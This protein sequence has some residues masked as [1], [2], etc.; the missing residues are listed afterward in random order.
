MG[1]QAYEKG[2]V[3]TGLDVIK[4]SIAFH[5]GTKQEGGNVVTSGGRVLALASF[6][7]DIKEALGHSFKNAENIKFKKKNYRKDIGFDLV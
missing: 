6:G 2:K 1:I 7:S 3:M 4:N 5:A